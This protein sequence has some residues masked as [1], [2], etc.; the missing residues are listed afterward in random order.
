MK[1]AQNCPTR[2]FD[3]IFFDVGG[4]L[5]FPNPEMINDAFLAEF[6]RNYGSARWLSSIY[7]A[8][9]A[10]DELLGQGKKLQNWWHDYF[11]EM[12]RAV[13]DVAT[14]TRE[15]ILVFIDLL[16]DL[17]H[18]KNLWSYPA[19]GCVELMQSLVS[20]SYKTAV[21]SN[22]DGRVQQQLKD[23]N[24]ADYF[25]FALDSHIVGCSKPDP[26]IFEMAADQS[27]LS[28]DRILYIGDFVNIDW[29]GA[30]NARMGA[31]IIDPASLVR[32]KRVPTV[33]ALSDVPGYLKGGIPRIK[34]SGIEVN[35][36]D[37]KSNKP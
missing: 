14:M 3:G 12:L 28:P 6:G 31:L 21:I 5:L 13:D 19:D 10:C 1:K 32:D 35:R 25:S 17:H 33:R 36:V 8:T 2:P 23:H 7:R 22:S 11:S 30:I 34:A 24:L 18:R 20:T 9:A 16:K 26:R 15:E 27:G 29:L 4:T 37:V